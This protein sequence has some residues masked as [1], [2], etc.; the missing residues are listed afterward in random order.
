MSQQTQV[1]PTYGATFII[2][3]ATDIE[4]EPESH[5]DM[6]KVS[7]QCAKPLIRSS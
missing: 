1:P 5:H 7:L 3:T 2:A 4:G 6:I